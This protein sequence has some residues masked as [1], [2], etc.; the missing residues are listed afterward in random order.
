M[1]MILDDEGR[2]SYVCL[3]CGFEDEAPPRAG[4]S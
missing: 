3:E 4:H 2:T 1:G